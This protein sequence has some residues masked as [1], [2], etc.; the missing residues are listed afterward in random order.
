MNKP[1]TSL[2]VTALTVAALGAGAGAAT[3][4]PAPFHPTEKPTETTGQ[5][6]TVSHHQE[7]KG[8]DHQYEVQAGDSLSQIAEQHLGGEQHWHGLY[9]ENKHTV[10]DNPDLIFPGQRLHLSEAESSPTHARPSAP[11]PRISP[12][13][14][15]SIT[16]AYGVPG[17]WKAGHHTGVD[18]DCAQGT[19]VHSVQN[20]KVVDIND[21]GSAYGLHV[22]IQGSDG[23]FTLYAHLSRIDVGVGQPVKQG[24]Q[25]GLSGQTGNASG[26]H[27]HF[28]V[29]TTN[30]YG[31][32]TDPLAYLNSL[33][34]VRSTEPR[35][36]TVQPAPK[37]PAVDDGTPKGYAKSQ[38][39]KYGWSQS[40]F[41]ALNQIW[42]HESSWD[43]NAVNPSSGAYGIPQALGHGHV[44]DLGDYKAQIDW[45]L[46]YIKDAYG[47]PSAAWV[48]W[49]NHNWY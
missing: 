36:H 34:T 14:G 22:V 19:K 8:E 30:H 17:P 33:T 47:D 9:E 6:K 24:D 7:H 10:G 26:P 25:I 12:V 23:T 48:F 28:E 42:E 16:E 44:Y 20:G 43:P 3:A 41:S 32:D 40:E 38:L 31:A 4:V 5:M 46:K 45:G 35:Q 29:R 13:E 18:Y 2:A 1:K 15:C 37:S 11:A 21:Q 49:Q 39:A 27:L